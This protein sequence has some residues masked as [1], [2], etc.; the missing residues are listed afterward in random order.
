MHAYIFWRAATVPFIGRH[1]R[2]GILAGVVVFLWAVFPVSHSLE[3]SGL[4]AVA[5]GFALVGTDWLGVAFLLFVTMLAVDLVTAFGFLFRRTAP[6]LRGWALLAGGVLAVIA[7]VQGARAPAVRSYEIQI[8]DLPPESNGTVVVVASDLHLGAQTDER[9]V[10]A[11]MEQIK[12]ERPDLVILAGD[13]VEGHGESE[14]GFLPA[15]RKLS[16]PLGVWA[17][18]GN[19]ES[20]APTDDPSH[21]SGTLLQEAGIQVLRDQWAEVRPGLILAGL[22]DLTSRHRRGQQYAG[23]VDRAL[24]GRPA[25]A[26]I[27]ISHTPWLGESAASRNVGLMLCGHTHGGQIWPF[28]YVVRLIYPLTAG[29]Y[30]VHGM[31]VIVCRGTGTWGPRMR[32]WYRSEILRVVLRPPHHSL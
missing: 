1:V 29:K 8:A 21:G 31:P 20:H 2:R 16:A 5:R 24:A 9:W 10:A 32:L 17:V 3:D 30:D 7:L 26:T 13:V 15:L 11:R 12:A 4:G 25:G 6:A 23:S 28:F 14:R 19:H 27:L 22:D 18:N